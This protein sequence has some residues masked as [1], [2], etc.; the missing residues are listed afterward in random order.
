M[1]LDRPTTLA[2]LTGNRLVAIQKHIITVGFFA[3]KAVTLARLD[4]VT[5]LYF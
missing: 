1:M 3:K 4:D 5:L 2:T